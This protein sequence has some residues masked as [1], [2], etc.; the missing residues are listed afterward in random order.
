MP[1]NTRDTVREGPRSL[2]TPLPQILLIALLVLL[3]AGCAQAQ[4]PSSSGKDQPSEQ[5]EKQAAEKKP[6]PAAG[7]LDHPALGEKGAPV[8]MVEYADYQ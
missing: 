4:S 5:P 1:T 3:V 2:A 6:E 8:V 7:G